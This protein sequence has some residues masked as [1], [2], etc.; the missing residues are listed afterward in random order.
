MK[1]DQIQTFVMRYLE[2]EQC[3]ILEKHPAYVTVKLSPSAD[4]ELNYRPYYWSFVERTGVAPET[5]TC[6]FIF[7]PEEYKDRKSV[8]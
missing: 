2:A 4:K 1:T 3:D 7:D 8:V 5:M 6:T